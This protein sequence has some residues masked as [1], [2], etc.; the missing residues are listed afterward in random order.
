[1]EV[2]EC[3]IVFFLIEIIKLR[4]TRNKSFVVRW[5]SFVNTRTNTSLPADVGINFT[6]TWDKLKQITIEHSITQVSIYI[7]APKVEIMY[8]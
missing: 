8:L 7:F 2:G 4:E 1:M 3:Y 5:I 6:E